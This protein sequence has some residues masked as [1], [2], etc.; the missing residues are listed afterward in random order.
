MWFVLRACQHTEPEPTRV[1]L[2]F[3]RVTPVE[4]ELATAES[5]KER[6]PLLVSLRKSL[7]G[8]PEHEGLIHMFR[9]MEA[10][11]LMLQA[12]SVAPRSKARAVMLDEY[13]KAL[14]A[15]DSKSLTIPLVVMNNLAWH[16]S[17]DQDPDRKARSLQLGERLKQLV[18]DPRI[19]P[20]AHDTYAWVLH[21]NER[22][23]EAETILRDLLKVADQPIYRYHLASVLFA[24]KKFDE[25]LKE[26]Q[27]ARDSPRPFTESGAARDLEYEIRE[28][29]RKAIGEQ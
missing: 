27:V 5:I 13:L 16:L 24:Q 23:S 20:D 14:D 22:H 2:R 25:A 18:P 28:A 21:R 4:A 26:V 17:E 7:E 11:R 10:E 9:G 8:L 29:R 1:C 3:I 6:Y 19:A 15:Y 12:A